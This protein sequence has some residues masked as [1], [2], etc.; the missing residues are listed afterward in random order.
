MKYAV[1]L[2]LLLASQACYAFCS[3]VIVGQKT[4]HQQQYYYQDGKQHRYDGDNYLVG[5]ITPDNY[6]MAVFKNSYG[7]PT[8]LGGFAWRYN[9][10]SPYITPYLVLGTVVGYED[11]LPHIGP[12]APY[13]FV[14]LDIH[15]INNKFGIMVSTIGSITSIG[16]RFSY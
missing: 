3:D 13:G 12:F 11:H 10:L 1:F 8:V 16:V 4:W 9:Q 15:N 6:I 5:C 7:D 2:V 14:G